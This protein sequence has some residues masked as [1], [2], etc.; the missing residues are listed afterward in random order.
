MLVFIFSAPLKS[1]IAGALKAQLANVALCQHSVIGAAHH[2]LHA[3]ATF[4]LK[5][6][7]MRGGRAGAV[8]MCT[9]HVPC[10]GGVGMG[11]FGPLCNHCRWNSEPGRMVI[12]IPGTDITGQH[13]DE[14]ADENQEQDGEQKAE[15]HIE[16]TEKHHD[17]PPFCRRNS[18]SLLRIRLT[19]RNNC[20]RIFPQPVT[21]PTDLF[22][23]PFFAELFQ[24]PLELAAA[25]MQV[26]QEVFQMPD[27]AA[28]LGLLQIE[29]QPLF[30]R[31]GGGA[32]PGGKFQLP[33]QLSH[34]ESQK[35]RVIFQHGAVFGKGEKKAENRFVCLGEEGRVVDLAEL[36]VSQQRIGAGVGNAEHPAVLVDAVNAHTA[37]D[38]QQKLVQR[39]ERVGQIL[40]LFKAQQPDDRRAGP[41]MLLIG[42]VQRFQ[43]GWVTNFLHEFTSILVKE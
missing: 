42:P 8:S 36:D 28:G 29:E 7:I 15:Q 22:E 9:C 35:D 13:P 2:K 6:H 1:E 32:G 18:V 3:V 43:T 16:P 12:L 26:E 33:G 40:A 27:L 25:A 19:F 24:H 37:L 30:Q 31:L 10:I 39:L 41:E 38:H 21:P 5:R 34:D 23:L 17:F 20:R 11:N 14:H 4:H